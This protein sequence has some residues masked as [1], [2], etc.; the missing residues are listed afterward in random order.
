MPKPDH[1]FTS[2]ELRLLSSV[3]QVAG[4]GIAILTPT[5]EAT[6]P[7]I[8]FAND[9]FCNLYGLTAD[10]VVGQT[11]VRFGIVERHQAIFDDMLQHVYENEAFDAEAAAK[12]KDGSE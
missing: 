7:R 5:H 9:G 1:R 4:Q 8:V 6:G 11:L 10:E 12:R 3:V 2:D